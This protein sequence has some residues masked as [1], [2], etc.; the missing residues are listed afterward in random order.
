MPAPSGIDVHTHIVPEKFPA[1]V[2]AAAPSNWPSMA[3]AHACHQHVMIAGKVYRTVSDQCWDMT[4][5]LSDMD[6]MG[7]AEQVISPM[8]ELLSYWLPA[9]VAQQLLRFIN[10]EI[11]RYV[12]AGGA[13]LTGLGAVPLQDM[14]LAIAELEY[15]VGTLRFPGVEIGSHIDGKPLGSPEFE[16]FFAAA[17][18]MG[19]CIFVHALRPHMDRVVGPPALEQALAFPGEIG[20]AA[21]SLITTNLIERHPGLRIAFSHCA[22]ALGLMLP[23]LES[24]RGKVPA[25]AEAITSSPTTQARKFFYDA[26]VY[27]APTLKHLS[28]LFGPTQI[29]LGTDYPFVV[30]EPDPHGRI[31][32]CGFDAATRALMTTGNARRF[33][34]RA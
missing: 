9:P 22:G 2:G 4:R 16:P 29:M 33:L 20:M 18:A 13:R 14:K 28:A 34:G 8:P 32:A 27:D 19:A 10:E 24:I 23:R 31:E 5:R 21:A 30:H 1:Y 15:V 12:A 6:G 25:L 11:A 3:P 26:L 17:E 7:V